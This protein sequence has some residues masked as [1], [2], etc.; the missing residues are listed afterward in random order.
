MQPVKVCCD[1]CFS[2]FRVDQSTLRCSVSAPWTEAYGQWLF[3]LLTSDQF[4]TFFSISF[5]HSFSSALDTLIIFINF[6][7][8][9]INYL[10]FSPPSECFS[11]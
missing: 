2:S 6:I 3:L 5:N 7:D 1:K 9:M 11:V 10:F 4:P 8:V